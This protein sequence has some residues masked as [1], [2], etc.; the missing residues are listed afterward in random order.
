MHKLQLTMLPGEYWYGGHTN[1][2]YLMPVNAKKVMLVDTTVVRSYG[3]ANTL[4]VSNKGRVIWS[5]TGFKT[6]FVFGRI[7][8]TGNKAKIGLYQA[9]DHTLRGAY[10]YAVDHFMPPDGT[11]PDEL[12]FR[13]PQYCTWI[14]FEHNQTQQ[15]IVDYAKSILDCGM[16]AGELIIDDGWQRSFGDWRFD[17]AKFADA[18]KM[19]DQLHTLGFKVILWIAPFVSDQAADFQKL[20]DEN[21]LVLDKNGRP[22]RRKW[23]NGA[24]YLLDFSNPAAQDWFFACTRYLTD[25]LGI[26]GFK[27]DAGDAMY[28]R[29]DD[30]TYGGV[31]ANGQSK[32]WALSARHYRF[33]ELRACFQCGGM[34][35]AQRMADKSH[36]WN[37]LGL[38][39]LLPNVL[40][41]GLSGYPYSC[42]DMIGG[43]QINDF[44]GPVE[45]LDHE[46]F[47]RYCEASA[48]MPMMQYSLNI[49]DLG[50]PETRRICREM[51]ALHAKYGDYI[52]ACAKA[53]SQ[54]GAPMVRA[55][56]YAY[57]HCGYGGI[58]DQFLLG[59]RILVAP[60]LKK[61]QRRRKV[62]IPTGKWRLGDKIYSNETVILP[63]PVDTLLYFERID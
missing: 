53:A 17:P 25:K 30:R 26:D 50:N 41:Q 58:T 9:D 56:E 45:K 15:G 27:Q 18:K 60:V 39:A 34:G 52:I 2:G 55:M 1:Y 54:T 37:F 59:D 8:C 20:K 44:R 10:H 24:D 19:T 38:G 32:L 16:P 11:Y 49:W 31:D 35:V 57:P 7:T 4:F 21:L 48:L 6:R 12:M 14:Q 46:L 61:G 3:Q 28:Y 29:D 23:W 51:S 43:G 63:C 40:I 33:N 62:C 36:R 47:A 13:I 22:A 5:E 42:P